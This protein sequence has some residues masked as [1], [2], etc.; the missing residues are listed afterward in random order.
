MSESVPE[1]QPVIEAEPELEKPE[2][3]SAPVAVAAAD[4]ILAKYNAIAA[5]RD[6]I[7]AELVAAKGQLAREREALARLEASLG[8]APARVVPLIEN[9]APEAADP[10]AEYLAAVES[11]DRKAASALF[12]K[13]KAAIWA[14]RNKISKA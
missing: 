4:S 8:L 9:A 5:E 14:H 7:R 6:T 10:V 1:A 13:H 12:A 3:P 2:E 11:G